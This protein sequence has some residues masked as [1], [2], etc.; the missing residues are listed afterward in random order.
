MPE[1]ATIA[2]KVLTAEEF[3][4]LE[5][6][7]F[8]GAAVDRADGYIHLSTAGQVTETVDRHFTGQQG[9]MIAAVDLAALG[10]MV[11]WE[12]SRHG[13]LFPHVYGPLPRAAV[14]AHGPLARLADG[15]VRLP[16]HNG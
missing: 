10:K 14:V 1:H 16:G 6:D 9:L 11:H 2:Y 3:L 15:T 13:Q 8:S 12:T 7:A 5:A 4:A